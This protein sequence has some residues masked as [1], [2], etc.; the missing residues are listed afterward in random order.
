MHNPEYYKNEINAFFDFDKPAPDI[1][2]NA[3]ELRNEVKQREKFIREKSLCATCDIV[4]F[5]AY[6]I[7]N[8]L[9]PSIVE[10]AVSV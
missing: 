6:F 8:K 5:R 7:Q 4:N 3:E 2:T 1:F 9:L 10:T